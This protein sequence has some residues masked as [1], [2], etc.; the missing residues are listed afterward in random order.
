[1]GFYANACRVKN[2]R[3]CSVKLPIRKFSPVTIKLTAGDIPGGTGVARAGFSAGPFPPASGSLDPP[4]ISGIVI[5]RL[6]ILDGPAFP[7][8]APKQLQLLGTFSVVPTS[9]TFTGG[10]LTKSY[11]FRTNEA[12]VKP[13]GVPDTWVWY[14][15]FSQPGEGFLFTTGQINT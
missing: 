6:L 15:T 10:D 1:M 2:Q 9:I 8:A 12:D 5:S 4:S 3:I 11:N 13:P 7:G 14:S